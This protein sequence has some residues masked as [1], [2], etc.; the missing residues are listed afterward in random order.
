MTRLT[1]R[2][3]LDLVDRR[4]GTAL[5]YYVRELSLETWDEHL[6]IAYGNQDF[7]SWDRYHKW[8]MEILKHR[9]HLRR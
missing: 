4:D 7:S 6:E 5:N 1:P 3:V 9:A 2:E 8:L